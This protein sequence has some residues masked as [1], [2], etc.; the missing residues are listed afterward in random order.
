[1]LDFPLSSVPTSSD[2]IMTS[3]AAAASGRGSLQYLCDHLAHLD[4]EFAEMDTIKC[5]YKSLSR[6]K[7][8]VGKKQR[9]VTRLLA[10][11]G[12]CCVSLMQTFLKSKTV[13]IVR[14][15]I[16]VR[17]SVST[18]LRLML[19]PSTPAD[20]LAYAVCQR[21]RYCLSLQ[22]RCNI[23]CFAQARGLQAGYVTLSFSLKSV[24]LSYATYKDFFFAGLHT[25]LLLS[26][27]I[28][29]RSIILFFL[30]MA[31]FR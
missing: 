24:S 19:H 14:L 4:I 27:S 8:H 10:K 12:V 25:L 5:S 22:Y 2:S 30:L 15:Q 7:R 13:W 17:G 26:H 20:K 11:N 18:N 9:P 1:M 21:D 16:C 28:V 29:L 23:V 31:L 6:R 3:L